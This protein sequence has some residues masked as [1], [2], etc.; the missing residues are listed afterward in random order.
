[1]KPLNKEAEFVIVPENVALLISTLVMAVLR[2]AS[3]DFNA[4]SGASVHAPK[5]FTWV[6]SLSLA[7]AS[8]SAVAGSTTFV[9]L[10]G[11][12]KVYVP[13][14]FTQAALALVKAPV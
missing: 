9:Q 11:L 3:A 14:Y 12:A 10:P 5:V 1:M 2:V 4:A 7:V 6:A 8:P 13:M